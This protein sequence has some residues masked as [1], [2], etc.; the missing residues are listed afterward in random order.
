MDKKQC[1]DTELINKKGSY[2]INL[3]NMFVYVVLKKWPL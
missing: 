3:Y 2:Q 1:R